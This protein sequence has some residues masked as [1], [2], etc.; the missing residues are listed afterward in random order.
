MAEDFDY[1]TLIGELASQDFMLS[2]QN[3]IRRGT[4][5]CEIAEESL[6][7][8]LPGVPDERGKE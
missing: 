5:Y 4:K 2:Q 1:S 8:N 6:A 7:Y 3:F